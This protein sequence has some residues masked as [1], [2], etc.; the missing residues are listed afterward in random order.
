[1]KWDGPKPGCTGF[2]LFVLILG[3]SIL[4]GVGTPSEI[5]VLSLTVDDE[6]VKI[7][8]KEPVRLSPFPGSVDIN[9]GPLQHRGKQASEPV[10]IRYKLEGVD[11][12]W[13]E[14]TGAP[15]VMRLS[16]GF[17]DQNGNEVKHVDY[18]AKGQS[19]GWNGSFE[20]SPL[21]H[22]REQ[23]VV[24]PDASSFWVVITS[25]GAPGVIGAFF[26]SDLTVK[27]INA[28]NGPSR[29]LVGMEFNPANQNPVGWRRDGLRVNMAKVVQV[30]REKMKSGLAI[31]DDDPNGH[32]QWNTLKPQGPK[33]T[34][35]ELLVL[36]WDEM[37]SVG[38]A[39]PATVSYKNP[40]PGFYRFS[41]NQLSIMGVPTGEEASVGFEVLT[42]YWR[43]PWFWVSAALLFAGIVFGGWRFRE[44]RK[45]QLENAR[46]TQQRVL[47]TERF[48]IARDIHDD[49][50]ARVTQI[51]LLSSAAQRKPGLSPETVADFD[52][53]SQMSRNLV[54]SLYE[55]VWA[56]SPENDH[57]DS[58]ATYICQMANQM[59]AQAGLKCRLSIPDLPHE[60]P[61]SSSI[62]H[63]LAMTVKEAI[64]NT[65]KHAEA[66]EVQVTVQYG[67]ALLVID[68][69][70][71]GKGFDPT[72]RRQGNGLANMERRM[73][74][75]GGRWTQS[76]RPGDGTRNRLELKLPGNGGA[77]NPPNTR[78][79]PRSENE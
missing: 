69:K 62:R 56:I 61:V 67:N 9:Y 45:L 35:L 44:A 28:T 79:S 58:L 49:F 34:P 39:T 38:M 2:C 66:T 22:R 72:A 54:G 14:M 1:M 12:E 59:C 57:L 46:L 68:V 17:L 7:S 65:I 53:V 71:D 29:D 37:F 10:R 8:T 64:H 77:P 42:P 30:G 43:T 27:A 19:A 3:C 23:V 47:E 48:R 32:A 75:A 24:P 13:Q 5:G 73:T 20:T 40:E 33:V 26:V 11:T 21:H 78:P 50:G 31:L 15:C 4:K 36:E 6:A 76:S 51:S 55:T 41:L 52:A 70:D 63:N 16:I 74:A 18:E 60:V 25:A